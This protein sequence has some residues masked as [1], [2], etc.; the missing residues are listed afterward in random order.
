MLEN[1][2][3]E[4][5]KACSR[6]KKGNVASPD[7]TLLLVV[8]ESLTTEEWLRIDLVGSWL[9]LGVNADAVAIKPSKT[10]KQESMGW[11]KKRRPT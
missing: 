2:P 11:E 10:P 4:S 1:F 9:R 8:Q 3:V 5:A 6:G 7:K